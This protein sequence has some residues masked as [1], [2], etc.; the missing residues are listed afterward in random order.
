MASELESLA[1]NASSFI[2]NLMNSRNSNVSLFLPFILSMTN[3]PN[4]SNPV[5]GSPNPDQETGE[6]TTPSDHSPDRIILINP[7]T[8]SMVVI[9]TSSSSSLVSLLSGLVDK[10]GQPPASKASI[11]GLPSVEICED[12]EKEECVVC[13]DE[14]G[15]GGGVVK[16]MPCKHRFHGE[17]VEK[18]LKIHGS[19]P[20]CRYKMPEEDGELSN[21]SENGR[22][23]R[24]IWMRFL[25][26]NER[27]SADN[28]NNQ[29]VS[30]DFSSENEHHL[31]ASEA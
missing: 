4:S 23:R 29:T 21:K 27:T 3:N 31:S 28:S 18:W 8:Q 26:G 24:E 2:E 16:E 30:A 1:A 10:K 19:C 22:S 15:V 7:F 17:C 5:Q 11:E 20:I 13:L 25:V 9:E 14:L 12:D 6:S